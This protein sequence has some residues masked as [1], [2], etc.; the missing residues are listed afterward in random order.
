MNN[1]IIA[2][3]II[4]TVVYLIP[5]YWICSTAFKSR[6]DAATVPPTVFFKP[7]IAPFVKVVTKRAQRRD[8]VTVEQYE[9]A[10][11]YEKMIFDE[12]ERI[13][14]KSHYLNRFG[15][16]IIIA[17]VSTL[18][19]LGLGTLTAYGF[20][21]FKVSGKN[22]WLFFILSTR[23]LPPV[24]VAIP[25]FL[26]YRTIGI[27]D[28]HIGMIFLYT[29][30]NLSF[31]VWLMKGFIDEIPVEYEEAA[32]VDGYTRFKV[33]WKI[34]LPQL[35][36]GMAATAVFCFIT[37]WNEYALALMLTSKK[38]QTAVPFI[39][40]QI[41]SGLTDWSTIAAGTFVFLMP[42]VI[43]TYCLRNHLLRGITFG[44]IRK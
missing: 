42:I 23:M 41:G 9:E 28:T 15:N 5:F 12:G 35:P 10:K 2:F 3:L 24:V 21:R 29:S 40:S 26:L 38:A 1:I 33:F 11:W 7:T 4:L 25:I 43:L 27:Y 22:D 8:V 34:V 31:S 44:A 32:M 19:A 18:L 6:L 13:L 20:S 14:K 16:S 17:S 39:P 36:T 30:L 37:A